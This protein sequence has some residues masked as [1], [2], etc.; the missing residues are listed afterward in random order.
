MIL[1]DNTCH[2]TH[3]L[4]KIVLFP[5]RNRP[6]VKAKSDSP[7]ARANH[8]AMV[9]A[10]PVGAVQYEIFVIELGP[11]KRS[12]LVDSVAPNMPK[13]AVMAVAYKFTLMM[14]FIDASKAISRVAECRE[15]KIQHAF[16]AAS[17]VTLGSSLNSTG[18]FTRFSLKKYP[19]QRLDAPRAPLEWDSSR[20][21][22]ESSTGLMHIAR[23]VY[24]TT[25]SLANR[26][27]GATRALVHVSER[28][29]LSARW[30]CAAACFSQTRL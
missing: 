17:R 12:G 14:E 26:D 27:V 6:A 18:M 23:F 29:A 2:A 24:D 10:L 8:P 20:W 9:V 25:R 30:L 16:G 4:A 11:Q 7:K 28:R 19:S 3:C 21:T 1:S 5:P 22:M 13:Y 15:C